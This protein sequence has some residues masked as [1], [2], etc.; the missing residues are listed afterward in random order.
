MLPP[1][2]PVRRTARVCG[3]L[4]EGQPPA[5]PQPSPQDSA[6]NLT[7]AQKGQKFRSDCLWDFM[8]PA[9]KD[10]SANPEETVAMALEC[11]SHGIHSARIQMDQSFCLHFFSHEIFFFALPAASRAEPN[12][13]KAI[14]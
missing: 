7:S 13:S 5:N 9:A 4:Q 2:V 10:S 8:D 6:G 14:S 3:H 11:T 12:S 1:A